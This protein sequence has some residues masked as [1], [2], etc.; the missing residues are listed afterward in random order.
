MGG[1]TKLNILRWSSV[2]TLRLVMYFDA[3]TLDSHDFGDIF[4]DLYFCDSRE[5]EVGGGHR[6]QRESSPGPRAG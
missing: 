2:F 1:G 3:S 5:A 6:V 4:T